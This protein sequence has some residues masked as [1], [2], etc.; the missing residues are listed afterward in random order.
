MW[1]RPRNLQGTTKFVWLVDW[2]SKLK[3]ITYNKESYFFLSTLDHMRAVMGQGLEPQYTNNM[4][5]LDQKHF[6]C[7][8]LVDVC[9]YGCYRYTHIILMWFEELLH[10]NMFGTNVNSYDQYKI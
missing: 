5:L 4:V 10:I 2:N 1:L 7:W 8:L 6:V 9:S 3:C